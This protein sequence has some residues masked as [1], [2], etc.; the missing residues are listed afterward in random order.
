MN[1]YIFIFTTLLFT[2][3]QLFSQN[4]PVLRSGTPQVME[5]ALKDSE[6]RLVLAQLEA[7]TQ[8]FIANKQTRSVESNYIIPLVVHVIHNYDNENISY[9]Q[10]DNALN[11]LNEDFQGLNDDLSTVIGEFTDIIGSPGFEFRLA[12]KDPDGNCTYGVNR[13]ASPMTSNASASKI[14]A[15]A[16]WDDKKYINIYVVRSFQESQSSAAAFAVNP[17]SGSEEY[18]DYIFFRY[19]YFADWNVNSDNGP[20]GNMYRRHVPTHEMGHFMNLAHPWGP[21]NDA[22]E[23]DNCSLDDGVEDTPETIGTLGGCPTSQAT[24]DG[25]VDNVQNFMEYSDCIC[26]FT[27]G[28]S[29]RMEAAVNSLAGNRWY[30]WQESNLIATGTDDESWNNEP[31]ADCAP[32]P[33]FKTS[34]TLGCA[35]T[36]V[37]FTDYTYNYR[38]E[39]ITYNWTFEG[40]TPQSSSFKNP[41]VEYLEPGNYDVTLTTCNGDNCNE[42]VLYDYI[43]ILSETNVL[44]EGGF[45]QSFESVSFPNLDTEIWW[46]GNSNGEQHWERTEDASNLGTSS[47]KIKSQ[48]YGYDRKS[49]EFSTPELDLSEFYTGGSGAADVWVSFDYAYARRLPYTAGELDDDGLV[50]DTFSIHHDELII[51]YKQCGDDVWTERPR[52]ST[53]PGYQGSFG[54]QQE[55]LITTSKIY[56]NSFVPQSGYV[57]DGGEWKRYSKNLNILESQ[58]VDDPSIVVKFEFVG[59][60]EDQFSF[61]LVDMGPMG[62]DYI[63]SSSIGGNWLYIDNVRIGNQS[64]VLN[65]R[66]S[67]L[68]DF[69]ISPNPTQ[70]GHGQIEFDVQEDERLYFG[71]SNLLGNQIDFKDMNVT[72]GKHSLKISEIFQISKEGTYIISISGKKTQLSKMVIVR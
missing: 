60:G 26:M 65:T 1:K 47:L 6:K 71:I 68:T 59:T 14:M 8:E 16:N 33:D 61:H 30:L 25:Q 50:S 54:A 7:F 37:T 67:N 72:K 22:A 69:S 46:G 29:I 23:E 43:T 39:N 3:N 48:N 52:L 45:S 35:G 32:I 19:D 40:G 62:Y 55:N 57:E 63:E 70:I 34:E 15:I 12:T 5:E 58:L 31:Y 41:T 27:Q 38:T 28:Q 36:Q 44:S 20:T 24:C 13:V 2:A 53:R 21:T 51:S 4:E 64:D 9:D 18:G 49:H 42:K 11:R 10:V 56:F 66:S 17:G